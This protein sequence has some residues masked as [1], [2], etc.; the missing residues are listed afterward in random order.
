MTHHQKPRALQQLDESLVSNTAPFTGLRREH[1][2]NILD[3]A[4]LRRLQPGATLFEEGDTAD[5]FYLLLDG[6]VRLMRITA[7]GEQVVI[8]HI[9]PGKLF[10]IAPALES[11]SFSMTAKAASEGLA[12]SWPRQ[13][14]ADFAEANPQFEGVTRA[15]VAERVTE[16]TDKIIE[17]ATQPVE[18]RIA[19]ALMRLT[20]QAG[21]VTAQGTEIDFPVTRQ[22]LSELTGTTMHSVSRYMSAWQRAGIVHSTRR[23]V[24]VVKPSDLE[25][26]A[27]KRAA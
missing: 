20:K 1:I 8:H 2:R 15:T 6:V 3:Q 16:M 14:W 9:M 25:E 23:R 13:I 26:V 22:D 5:T 21:R 4:S 7:Q 18:R 11:R 12:L 19:L 17:L 10:G 24:V 27:T